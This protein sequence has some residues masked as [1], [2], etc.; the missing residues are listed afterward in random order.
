MARTL[1]IHIGAHRTA[2]SAIQKFLLGNYD[3]LA[4]LGYLQVNRTGRQHWLMQGL[5][6]GRIKAANTARTIA[7]QADGM[8]GPI[9]SA[10]LSDEDIS[11]QRDLSYLLPL[12]EHFDVK[13]VYTLRRQD[14]WL[15][16][17]Y[18][19]NIKW[20]WQ[21]HLSHLT[22]PEFLDIHQDFH[23]IRY[24]SYIRHLEDLFG[25]D[26]I[27]LTVHEKA[28]MPGG[29]IATF[30]RH[31]GIAELDGFVIPGQVN[32]SFTPITSEFM[33]RLPLDQAAPPHRA[34]F[35]RI[36][37]EIDRNWR[38]TQGGGSSLLLTRAE[39]EALMAGFE[40]E[41][42]AV[43]ERYFGRS[44]LFEEDLPPADAPLAEMRLPA[45]PEELM[46]RFVIPLVEGIIRNRQAQDEARP[47]AARR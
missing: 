43:A 11:C 45:T 37:H 40:P 2:T 14:L 31:L 16:S 12:R 26:N 33:R 28:H 34:E 24:D 9:H 27:L 20:Q 41:N 10:I 47:A 4:E 23:W 36:L 17:W 44:R 42:R 5:A 3:R 1:Y 46:D 22:F 32:P 25:R 30:C 19:Q 6:S 8:P 39:R 29:P 21:P 15:E 38:K 18:Y 35:E 13:I 7:D